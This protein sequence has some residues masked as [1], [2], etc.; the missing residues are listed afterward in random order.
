MEVTTNVSTD[1]TV[2]LNE[3]LSIQNIRNYSVDAKK[4]GFKEV[5]RCIDGQYS[6][7]NYL[8]YL[9]MAWASHHGV[10]IS[11][12]I[13]WHIISSELASHI[14]DNAD[15]YAELFTTTPGQKQNIIIPTGDTELIDLLVIRDELIRRIP[16]DANLFLPKFSTTTL[17]SEF[18]FAASFADAMQVYYNYMMFCCGISKIKVLVS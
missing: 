4:E 2:V 17:N 8:N 14:K 13:L 10:V 5:R 12:D 16:M 7:K 3:G 9:E 6:H 11:P 1:N 18:A 15:F